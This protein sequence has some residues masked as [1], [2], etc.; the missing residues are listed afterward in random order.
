M[1]SLG[2]LQPPD[3]LTGAGVLVGRGV[4]VAVAVAVG[5]KVMVAVA[6]GVT[7]AVAVGVKVM[8]GV[9]VL[10]ANQPVTVWPSSQP[11]TMKTDKQ[12]IKIN[13]SRVTINNLFTISAF[14]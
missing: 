5:V 2:P 1:P 8:V 9:G 12:V 3:E 11:L 6:V 14:R 10:V 4:A 7:V 13:S